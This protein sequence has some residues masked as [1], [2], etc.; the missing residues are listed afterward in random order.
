MKTYRLHKGRTRG[1]TFLDEST[2]LRV[3]TPTLGP[4]TGG[5][6]VL[7]GNQDAGRVWAAHKPVFRIEMSRN[8]AERLRD[9]LNQVL[10]G[11]ADYIQDYATDK[12]GLPLSDV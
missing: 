2:G 1:A 10:S 3:G 4:N 8:E 7:L 11:A 6:N 12:P 9:A 5:V